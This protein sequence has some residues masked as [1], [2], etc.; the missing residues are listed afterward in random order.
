MNEWTI[1]VPRA[2]ALAIA[3][4]IERRSQGWTGDT[5]EFLVEI[6]K[7][8]RDAAERSRRNVESSNRLKEYRPIACEIVVEE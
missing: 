7:G 3:N 2:K 6:V 8:L 4:E 5:D 1:I